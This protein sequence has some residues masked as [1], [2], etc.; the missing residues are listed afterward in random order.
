MSAL[1]HPLSH[2]RVADKRT[3]TSSQRTLGATVAM[4][5]E[6]LT[7]SMEMVRAVPH[8]GRVSEQE[9]AKVRAIADTL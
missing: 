3:T 1:A 5:L 8:T 6:I 7:K 4:I 9:M 2:A